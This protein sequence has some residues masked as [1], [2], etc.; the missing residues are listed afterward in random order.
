MKLVEKVAKDKAQRVMMA[1]S[2]LR[3]A[4]AAALSEPTPGSQ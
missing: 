2:Q 1:V 3:L 4:L